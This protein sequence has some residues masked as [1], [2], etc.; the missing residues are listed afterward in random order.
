MAQ[1]RTKHIIHEDEVEIGSFQLQLM[2]G[3]TW[4]EDIDEDGLDVRV[5][6]DDL[7]CARHDVGI[8]AAADVQ[9]VGGLAADL[10]DHIE[11]K[12]FRASLYWGASLLYQDRLGD[13]ESSLRCVKRAITLKP[14]K[15]RYRVAAA[16]L[17]RRMGS[18]ECLSEYLESAALSDSESERAVLLGQLAWLQETSF[19]LEKSSNIGRTSVLERAVAANPRFP[20]LRRQLLSEYHR[21]QSWHKA[22]DVL[23]QAREFPRPDSEKF[24]FALRAARLLRYHLDR[25]TEA[26]AAYQRAL[27]IDNTS[28]VGFWEMTSLLQDTQKWEDLASLLSKRI[29]LGGDANTL[30]YYRLRLSRLYYHHLDDPDRSLSTLNDMTAE[31][32]RLSQIESL[33]LLLETQ[34]YSDCVGLLSRESDSTADSKEEIDRLLQL[35]DIH[36]RFLNDSLSAKKI[37]RKVLTLSSDNKLAV[38]ALVDLLAEDKDWHAL[39]DLFQTELEKSKDTG[40]RAELSAYIGYIYAMYLNDVDKGVQRVQAAYEIDR[41]NPLYYDLFRTLSSQQEE[42]P[43]Q[44]IFCDT[45]LKGGHD[46]IDATDRY[47]FGT[48]C[49]VTLDDDRIA[50]KLYEDQMQS[51]PDDLDALLSLILIADRNNVD[52]VYQRLES[53]A[54]LAAKGAVTPA[55]ATVDDDYAEVLEFCQLWA[56]AGQRFS[57]KHKSDISKHLSR[58]AWYALTPE[59]YRDRLRYSHWYLYERHEFYAPRDHRA[60]NDAGLKRAAMIDQTLERFSDSEFIVSQYLG[61]AHEL[62]SKI[63]DPL[64]RNLQVYIDLFLE[65]VQ[66]AKQYSATEG[67]HAD[68]LTLMTELRANLKKKI[69]G[70]ALSSAK[71]LSS[72]NDDRKFSSFMLGITTLLACMHGDRDE[73]IESLKNTRSGSASSADR[74]TRFLIEAL[75]LEIEK[76]NGEPDN[77]ADALRHFARITKQ[78]PYRIALR[79]EAAQIYAG[80]AERE[81]EAL[82]ILEELFVDDPAHLEA[83]ALAEVL[84][85]RLRHDLLLSRL[86]SRYIAATA[87]TNE[88]IATLL[89][90]AE[91]ASTGLKDLERS[92]IDYREVLRLDPLNRIALSGQSFM[93]E[94]LKRWSE[95]IE[96]Y[97]AVIEADVSDEV[98]RQ[99]QI[100]QGRIW[101]RELHEPNRSRT[102]LESISTRDDD[103]FEVISLVV[104]TAKR[105]QEWDR[106]KSLL[107]KVAPSERPDLKIWAQLQM[108][109]V[110]YQQR[111]DKEERL[112]HEKLAI[113]ACAA[114]PDHA[115]ILCQYFRDRGE[116]EQLVDIISEQ[117]GEGGSATSTNSLRL[118]V[119]DLI[120]SEL[121]QPSRALGFLREFLVAQPNDY[122]ARQLFAVALEK[123]GDLEA[124]LASYR[125]VIEFMV[126]DPGSFD[127]IS[128]IAAMERRYH[129]ERSGIAVSAFLTRRQDTELSATF[130]SHDATLS[131]DAI[132]GYYFIGDRNIEA[133]IRPLSEFFVL[134]APYVNAY[135]AQEGHVTAQPNE[136][137]ATMLMELRSALGV[138]AVNFHRCTGAPARVALGATPAV[139]L[140]DE[141]WAGS[142]PDTFIF[143]A[144]FGCALV[145]SGGAIPLALSNT[146][147][148]SV[149]D[150]IFESRS[151]TEE[152]RL[153]RKELLR[154]IPRRVR[155]QLEQTDKPLV[156]AAILDHFRLVERMAAFEI[157]FTIA[158]NPAVAFNALIKVE[159]A[160]S[161]PLDSPVVRHMLRFSVSEHY[162]RIYQSLWTG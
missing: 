127:G 156:N 148:N 104:E 153:L 131:R 74:A 60:L 90:H 8:G 99:A 117:I 128:R 70:D 34:R 158:N 35:A 77:I 38:A 144:A 91:L 143:W 113:A 138:S 24:V 93:L 133:S 47:R 80:I 97:Q 26:I 92:L 53:I 146:E 25:P 73:I 123:Q 78:E 89:K 69:Y 106:A 101:L 52:Y 57:L 157:A 107:A 140:S 17:L 68:Y 155:R 139:A 36:A 114:H 152:D 87:D 50:T 86:Y 135:F 51:T 40:E 150:A 154:M 95:A 105:T 46:M 151:V 85:I 122:R 103:S 119:A 55:S 1:K 141:I 31:G 137:Q 39:V 15:K 102:I 96:A 4:K 30:N 112:R 23:L 2:F 81:Q 88:Q 108:A 45:V 43:R 149:V 11:S 125:T 71:E 10:V 120:L 121:D 12:G 58:D 9:E 75:G 49:E 109:D 82:D 79:M 83:T 161:D 54:A 21:N 100:A 56:D 76:I 136:D 22:L 162:D 118:L 6:V 130:E 14:R 48:R 28:W 111:H 110:A 84:L 160:Y 129:I 19:P 59:K 32:D 18:S 124:A 5:I 64:D 44:K 37:Y 67:R 65:K 63:V 159:S 134:V 98:T 145:S 62:E 27:E 61:F 33:N 72:R 147:L 41:S 94:K 142:T 16:E 20:L 42:S 3:S 7:E 66:R 132:P 115:D 116:I 29:A 126:D 13:L